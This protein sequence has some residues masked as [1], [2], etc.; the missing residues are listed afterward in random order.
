M[1]GDKMEGFRFSDMGK[2]II[3]PLFFIFLKGFYFEDKNLF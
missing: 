3:P 2:V 1:L